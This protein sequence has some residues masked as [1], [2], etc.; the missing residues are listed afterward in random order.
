[1]KFI[2][3]SLLFLL[4]L[5]FVNAEAQNKKQDQA[6]YQQ[7]ITKRAEKIVAQLGITDSIQYKRVTSIIANQYS[8]IN[9]HHEEIDAT[10]KKLK[11]N[12][13]DN[14]VQ[15]EKQSKAYQ[16]KAEKKLSKIHKNYIKALEKELNAAQ[17]EQVKDGMTYGVLPITLK[18]YHEMLPNL[19]EEQKA[20][21]KAF[22]TEAREHAMDAPSS[23]KKHAWFGKYKGK[24]NNYLSAQ[25]IDM[26]KAGQEWEQ[27]IKEAKEK[28]NKG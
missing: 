18:G 3:Q 16:E 12:L 21:I 7:V 24:I 10:N 6:A 8:I 26:K 27:R 28:K 22:L 11:A 1:M 13:K 5:G 2:S 23:E 17:I 20:Q 19:N 15:L 9:E 25:G 14:K 4:C